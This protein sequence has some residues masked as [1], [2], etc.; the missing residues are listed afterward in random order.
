MTVAGAALAGALSETGATGEGSAELRAAP[1][2]VGPLEMWYPKPAEK[3]LEALPIGCGRLSAMVFGRVGQERLQLNEDTVWAGGPHN[4]DSPDALAALPE[5]RRLVFEGKYIEAEELVDAKF[6]GRP[7]RQMPY[8]PVGDLTLEFPGHGEVSEYRR[9]LD[10]DTATASVEYV[11][12]GVRYHREVIAS[13]PHQVIAIHLTA[14]KHG[15]L[16]FTARFESSQRSTARSADDRTI[17]LEGISGDFEHLPGSVKFVA[18]ARAVVHGGTVHTHD[19]A[20]AIEGADSVTL[21]VSI[22]TSYRKYDDVSGDALARAQEFLEA[23]SRVSYADLRKSHIADYQKL[24]HRVAIDL[25][26]S[27]RAHLPTDARIA[28]FKQGG[29][30]ALAALHFQFGRY[31]LISC[32]RPGSQPANLQGNWNNLM[33]PPWQS[34]Y[35]VNINTEM[36]YW[37][38]APANLL[39]CYEPLFSM[40]ADLSVTGQ[41]TAKSQYGA[42]GWVCHHNTDAWRGT[43]PVDYAGPGM[44]PCGG[45][46]LSKSLWDHYEFT[47]DLQALRHHYPI[48][49]GA[50]EFFLES[51]VEDPKH[52]W[53]VT[54]PSGSPEVGHPGPGNRAICAGPTID[55]LLIGDLFDACDHAAS[56]LGEDAEFRKRVIATRARLAPLQIGKAGQL[57]EW[58]EDWDVEN[59][60]Q[61]NRHVS[62]L[63]ALFPGSRISRRSTPELFAAAKKS[64]E[65]RG[66][67]ATGWSLA[68][69]INLWARLEDGEHSY[70][71]VTD[72]LSPDRTAPNLF[73]LHPPFQIDGNFGAVSGICE[74]LLQ[75][76]HGE[77]HL[78]PALPSAFKDGS[79]RGLRART[80]LEV[81]LAWTEGRIRSGRIHAHRAGEVCVRCATPLTVHSGGAQVE[82]HALEADVIA[83][84]ATTGQ[85]YELLAV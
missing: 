47:G 35:T 8:Q 55:N 26:K 44:W 42:G 80:G 22:G 14:D 61:H 56:L 40:L 81:D 76:Q 18:L 21:L 36:N 19:G 37:P 34:K 20:L 75:S 66:D 71:L 53:L 31:L 33:D 39:E 69:K 73:D 9:R 59:E 52:G 10:L 57:Q 7:A 67:E 13:A 60:D 82:T 6:I 12:Q 51:L 74:M 3:W 11:A 24:F 43:A 72:L 17:A 4:Y 83:F 62:H 41:H 45:A 58:L 38:A 85:S 27:E 78:L 64:L 50:A 2:P 1:G 25:G 54:C 48:M 16:T 65:M 68:W 63:Y 30:P 15:S 29:D 79:V 46:W 70:K 84:D 5:I 77:L 23:A 28:A 49:K 32:S